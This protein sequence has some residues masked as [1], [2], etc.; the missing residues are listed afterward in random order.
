MPHNECRAAFLER[1]FEDLAGEVSEAVLDGDIQRPLSLRRDIANVRGGFWALDTQLRF[2]PND[3]CGNLSR[4]PA[5]EVIS[6]GR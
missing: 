5:V 3:L 2:V 4:E 6:N 1:L